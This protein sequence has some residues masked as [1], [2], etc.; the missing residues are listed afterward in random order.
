MMYRPSSFV[1]A[2]LVKPVS[3]FLAATV[4][5]GRGEPCSSVTVPSRVTRVVWAADFAPVRKTAR[6]KKTKA[7][8]GFLIEAIIF[9]SSYLI[10]SGWL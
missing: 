1:M 6:A 8:N 10:R 7:N 2:L 3:A 9:P 4:A 5:P